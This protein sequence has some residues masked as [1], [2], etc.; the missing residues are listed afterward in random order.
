M[1]YLFSRIA[2][3]QSLSWTKLCKFIFNQLC[4]I[5]SYVRGRDLGYS[6]FFHILEKYIHPGKL[7]CTFFSRKVSTV[8]IIF[9][10]WKKVKPSH[11]RS[12]ND[13]TFNFPPLRSRMTRRLSFFPAKMTLVHTRALVVLRKF[14]SHSRPRLRIWRSLLLVIKETKFITSWSC[15]R[16]V[17]DKG[18]AEFEERLRKLFQALV[19][20]MA[21][22]KNETLLTQVLKILKLS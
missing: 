3:T 7:H 5:V 18:Q 9:F 4:A 10:F 6:F 8:I 17:G 21:D 1:R 11:D 15:L 12:Q 20:L 14:R 16:A 22:A 2:W 19:Q 13:K